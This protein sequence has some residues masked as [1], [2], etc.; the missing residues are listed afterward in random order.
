MRLV[1]AHVLF[2][3]Q[4]HERVPLT[5][6]LHVR[7]RPAMYNLL[8]L[9]RRSL[10]RIETQV[11]PAHPQRDEK[12]ESDQ[13]HVGGLR[14]DVRR[15][16]FGL[17]DLSTDHVSRAEECQCQR[18]DRVLC[19]ISRMISDTHDSHASKHCW[20]SSYCH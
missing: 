16:V 5:F 9:Q 12:L 2:I 20:P 11:D 4:I 6:S 8:L 7:I 17:E 15:R 1:T 19:A 3:S 18:V 13:N 10:L 14:R